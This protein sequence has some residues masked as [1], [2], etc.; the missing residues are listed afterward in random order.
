MIKSFRDKRTNELFEVGD[1]RGVPPDVRA[2]AV[3]KLEVIHSAESVKDFRKPP[4]TRFHSL[5]GDRLGQ[6][7]IAVNSQWRICFRF[8]GGHAYDVEFCDYH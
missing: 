1:A 3:K 6:Y 5:K 8:I 7:S 4:G 2:R